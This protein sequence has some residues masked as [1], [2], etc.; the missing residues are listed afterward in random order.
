LEK[1]AGLGADS[2]KR[3]GKVFDRQKKRKHA[4]ETLWSRCA[5][6]SLNGKD[7]G[8]PAHQQLEPTETEGW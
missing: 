2:E 4:V 6:G 8:K 3:D 7:N 1:G 5:S